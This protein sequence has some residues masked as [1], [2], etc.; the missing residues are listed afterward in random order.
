MEGG[1]I[2]KIGFLGRCLSKELFKA[3]DDKPWNR[4]FKRMFKCGD[5]RNRVSGVRGC[6]SH[7]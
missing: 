1:F 4:A 5:V 6:S 3:K 7:A 2:L